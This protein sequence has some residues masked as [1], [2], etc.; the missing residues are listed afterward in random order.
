MGIVVRKCDG[1]DAHALRS[2]D[3]F[4]G[5]AQP[6]LI[7]DFFTRPGHHLIGAFD[8][9]DLI[10]FVSGIEI[11]H[12]DKP[13]EMLLYELGIDESHRRRGIGGE[14]VE[15]LA[16]LAVDQG[17]SIM[18]V[19]LDAD[20]DIAQATYRSAGAATYQVAGVMTWDFG[21]SGPDAGSDAHRDH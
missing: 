19:P 6:E 11:A 13:V 1:A 8:R 20:D 5:P 16:A 14:L 2:S 15:A 7:D 12:P 10:G 3:V 21:R 17:C 4:D 18:W 9:E